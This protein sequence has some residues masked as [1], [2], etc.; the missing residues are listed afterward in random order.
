MP[1]RKN[2]YFWLCLLLSELLVTSSFNGG[3]ITAQRTK[4][5]SQYYNLLVRNCCAT[6]LWPSSP[7]KPYKTT[8]TTAI[9]I[10]SNW[11]RWSTVK[12]S[13]TPTL[14][15]NSSLSYKFST[16]S[17]PLLPK[18]QNVKLLFDKTSSWGLSKREW[19]KDFISFTSNEYVKSMK[20]FRWEK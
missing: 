17:R 1:K 9:S 2:F 10:S 11:F 3:S 8:E 13:N 14:S 15:L 6:S 18:S 16:I 12:S 5:I 7:I 20:L 4:A 19:S